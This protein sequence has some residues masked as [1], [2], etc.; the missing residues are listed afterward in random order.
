[1]TGER[2]QGKNGHKDAKKARKGREKEGEAR[3]RGMDRLNEGL[4]QFGLASLSS[5]LKPLKT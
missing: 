5:M 4:R 1:M 3:H 2:K